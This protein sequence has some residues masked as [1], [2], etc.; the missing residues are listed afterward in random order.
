[1]KSPLTTICGAVALV[2]GNIAAAC[3][4]VHPEVAFWATIMAS[5]AGGLGLMFARDNKTSDE[6][7]NQDATARA[8]GKPPQ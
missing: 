8:V 5:S 4:T 6:D 1:M 3:A 7:V 2:A